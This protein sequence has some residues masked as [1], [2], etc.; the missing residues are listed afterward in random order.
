M[1]PRGAIN[2][3]RI[4]AADVRSGAAPRRSGPTQRAGP[5][6]HERAARVMTT[7][8][9]TRSSEAHQRRGGDP[10]H[11]RGRG[12]S[13]DPRSNPSPAQ[14]SW[15]ASST[16]PGSRS[17]RPSPSPRRGRARRRSGPEELAPGSGPRGTGHRPRS[18]PVR[19][20][21][22]S[23]RPSIPAGAKGASGERGVTRGFH[24]SRAS[25]T[26]RLVTHGSIHGEGAETLFTHRIGDTVAGG[27]DSL[28]S[29]RSPAQFA[30]EGSIQAGSGPMARSRIH[31]LAVLGR[32]VAPLLVPRS[33]S[34]LPTTT[35][36][37]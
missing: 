20:P 29:R 4:L 30:A 24:G 1:L 13:H 8:V 17:R 26:R 10:A 11:S 18:L 15:R 34:D 27:P 2:L 28:R 22:K 21:C 5:D 23:E 33:P 32:T 7:R 37:P 25:A 16:P 6:R 35:H 14:S 31:E 3:G 36:L 19:G 9:G 12:G